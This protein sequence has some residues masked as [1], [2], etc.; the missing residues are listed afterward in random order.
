MKLK[1]RN[2]LFMGY[3]LEK[4]ILEKQ[5]KSRFFSV[6]A[7]KWSHSKNNWSNNFCNV[8]RHYFCDNIYFVA[9]FS[10]QFWKSYERQQV[11]VYSF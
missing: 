3:C 9:I 11:Q 8:Q 2:F 1:M 10:D 6:V 4:V 7:L 5:F